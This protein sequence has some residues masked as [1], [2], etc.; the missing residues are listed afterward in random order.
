M[1]LTHYAILNK[2]IIN[3]TFYI[4]EPNNFLRLIIKN[5]LNAIFIKSDKDLKTPFDLT[6]ITTPPFMHKELLS[7]CINRGD[8]KIF[9]EKPF[10]G[11]SNIKEEKFHKNIFV[12]YVL[13]FNP[14]INWLKNN[15]NPDEILS[16]DAKYFSNTIEKKPNGW[17]NSNFSGVLNEM[18]SHLIDLIQDIINI[19][20][21]SVKNSSKK[22][23][24][25]DYDDIVR[26][27][28]LVNQSTILNIHLNWVKKDCRKPTFNLSLKLKNG[29]FITVDQQTIKIIKSNKVIE[30]K[31]VTDLCYSIPYYLRGLDFTR[32]IEDLLGQCNTISTINSAIRVNKIM[33]SI[34]HHETNFRG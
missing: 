11:H 7:N 14:C 24:I 9:I 17:R 34:Y 3:K 19:K 2:L 32:Q 12:G 18:G 15:I 27:E 13:R 20:Q 1:G 33:N 22:S 16:I 5:N 31:N 28:L 30:C 10:G 29:K 6:L 23:I 4:V 25:S 26:A 21:F 8:R